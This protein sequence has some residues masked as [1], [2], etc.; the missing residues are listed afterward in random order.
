MDLK[1]DLEQGIYGKANFIMNRKNIIEK[2]G[3]NEKIKK[4]NNYNFNINNNINI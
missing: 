1:K 3:K 2:R 4:D